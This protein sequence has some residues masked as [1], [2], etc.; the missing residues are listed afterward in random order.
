MNQV[1]QITQQ[2]SDL[3]ANDFVK[4][5]PGFKITLISV[6]KVSKLSANSIYQIEHDEFSNELLMTLLEDTKIHIKYID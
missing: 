5:D 4:M 2:L 6:N 1:S 3:N